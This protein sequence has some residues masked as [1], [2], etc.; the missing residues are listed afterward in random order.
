MEVARAIAGLEGARETKTHRLAGLV[1]DRPCT[2]HSVLAARYSRKLKAIRRLANGTATH[3]GSSPFP[4]T[5]RGGTGKAYRLRT[6][7]PTATA[8]V[9]CAHSPAAY[10]FTIALRSICG[11]T[12][13]EHSQLLL[14]PSSGGR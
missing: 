9:L 2:E 1:Q 7:M 4:P 10:L 6:S 8:C 12:H 11:M 5:G 14:Q 13:V 3:K